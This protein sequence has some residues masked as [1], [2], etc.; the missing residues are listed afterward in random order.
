MNER[1]RSLKLGVSAWPQR[2]S[3]RGILQMF[4]DQLSKTL[5]DRG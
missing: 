4:A 5:S 2:G 1:L 3:T